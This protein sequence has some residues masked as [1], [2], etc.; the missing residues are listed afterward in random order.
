MAFKCPTLSSDFVCQMRQL[1]NNRP[2]FLSVMKLV[3]DHGTQRTM[4]KMKTNFTGKAMCRVLLTNC[5]EIPA[6]FQV[7]C[8]FFFRVG[9]E[10]VLYVPWLFATMGA[11][12]AGPCEWKLP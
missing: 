6:Y 5:Q 4:S 7:L 3:H 8:I 9:H 1:K 12:K 11:K 2:R 10:Q